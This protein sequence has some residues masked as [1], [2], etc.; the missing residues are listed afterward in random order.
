MNGA[1]RSDREALIAELEA[2]GYDTVPG[3]RQDWADWRA[4]LSDDQIKVVTCNLTTALDR[5]DPVFAEAAAIDAGEA[6][7]TDEFPDISEM[8][9]A[10]RGLVSA[11]GAWFAANPPYLSTDVPC[12]EWERAYKRLTDLVDRIDAVGARDFGGGDV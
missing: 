8:V 7:A 11:A 5:G 1:P 2:L 6:D 3:V 9:D 4:R 10:M 12:D